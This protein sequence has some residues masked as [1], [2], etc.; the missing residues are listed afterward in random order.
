MVNRTKEPFLSCKKTKEEKY[1]EG[2]CVRKK[3][4]KIEL[5]ERER[6]RK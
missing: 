6:E 5:Y 2:H 4:V 3:K 1:L